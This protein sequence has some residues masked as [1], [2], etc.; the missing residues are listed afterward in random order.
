VPHWAEGKMMATERVLGYHPIVLRRGAQRSV[1]AMATRNFKCPAC[2]TQLTKSDMQLVLS[3][4]R[5][6]PQARMYM[7]APLSPVACPAC[8]VSIPA[9]RIVA[10]EYD[11]ETAAKPTAPPSL[12]WVIFCPIPGALAGFIVT[13]ILM[14]LPSWLFSFQTPV[15]VAVAGALL[16]AIGFLHINLKWY[17]QGYT[18]PGAAGP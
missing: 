1:Q 4:A 11:L 14:A 10:G 13:A 15:I 6:T 3:Q 16:G 18:D 2:G 17:R 12:A 5:E 9:D 7:T 8:H